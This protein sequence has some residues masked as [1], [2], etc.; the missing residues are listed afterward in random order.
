MRKLIVEPIF[1]FLGV[2]GSLW[3]DG[4]SDELKEKK[5]LND[6][7]ITLSNE[8]LKN[9]DYTK[10]HIYQVKNLKYMTDVILEDYSNITI[11]KLKSTHDNNPFFHDIDINGK[12]TYIKQYD[13]SKSIMW[14]MRGFLAWEPADIFFKSMLNSGK[15]L[16]IENDN[17]RT[18]IESIYTRHEERVIGMTNFTI[19]NSNQIGDWFFKRREEYNKDIDYG[20]IFLIERDQKLKNLLKDKK[21]TL[22]GRLVSLDF[23]LQSLQ[24]VVSIISAEYK[25][26]N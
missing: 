8:I 17:L 12:T 25:S 19:K 21:A 20:D 2:L 14:M 15:L 4:Y 1:I 26:V 24:N 10:E 22:E 6:S 23:Y 5:E 11:E 9:I 13:N 3:V 18:E 16:E 7:I